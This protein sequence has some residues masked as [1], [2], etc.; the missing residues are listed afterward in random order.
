MTPV[1]KPIRA[2]SNM[3]MFLMKNT[4]M[5]EIIKNIIKNGI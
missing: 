5:L 3:E 2:P 4:R 1:S